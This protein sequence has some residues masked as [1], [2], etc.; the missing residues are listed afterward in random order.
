MRT[1]A[2][3]ID[4]YTRWTWKNRLNAGEAELKRQR[5]SERPMSPEHIDHILAN[6][7]FDEP[8]GYI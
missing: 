3:V 5:I 7:Y 6:T 4:E 1:T 2:Q 8:W